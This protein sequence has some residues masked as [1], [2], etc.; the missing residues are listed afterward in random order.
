M[1]IGLYNRDDFATA[2]SVAHA[3]P[4]EVAAMMGLT[5]EGGR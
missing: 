2:G 4:D 1:M 5:Q 3:M